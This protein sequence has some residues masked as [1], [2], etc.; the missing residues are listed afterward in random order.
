MDE[1]HE[2][3][4]AGIHHRLDDAQF[5]QLADEDVAVE[6][7]LARRDRRFEQHAVG[8]AGRRQAR[9]RDALEGLDE[10]ADH[11]QFPGPEARQRGQFVAVAHLARQ[12]RKRRLDRLDEYRIG[13]VVGHRFAVA[14]GH[15]YEAGVGLGRDLLQHVACVQL[16]LAGQHSIHRCARPAHALGQQC[17]GQGAELFVVGG[18]RLPSGCAACAAARGGRRNASGRSRAGAHCWGS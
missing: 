10:V 7:V 14:R 18:N 15:Q 12:H 2:G 1:A 8:A 4:R 3:L 13:D 16:V 17:R 6:V 5:A 11:P 9:P